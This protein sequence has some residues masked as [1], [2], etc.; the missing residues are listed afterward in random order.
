MNPLNSYMMKVL[1]SV[2][3]ILLF[4]IHSHAATLRSA[5][6]ISTQ[7]ELKMYQYRL[8]TG[9]MSAL[10][11]NMSFGKSETISDADAERLFINI[12]KGI[13]LL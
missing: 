8:K 13:S 4:T 7:R 1:I 6:E 12:V 5:E 9:L 10:V 11:F 2:F 3:S